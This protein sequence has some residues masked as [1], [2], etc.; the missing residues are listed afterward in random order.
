MADSFCPFTIRAGVA[1]TLRSRNGRPLSRYFPELR[2]PPG[3][4]VLD[5]FPRTVDQAQALEGIL[6]GLGVVLAPIGWAAGTSP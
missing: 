5:G 4:Y 1:S 3:G 2:F 6:A